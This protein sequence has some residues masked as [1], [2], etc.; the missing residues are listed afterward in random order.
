VSPAVTPS[1]A[2]A[3][4]DGYEVRARFARAEAVAVSRPRLL[5]GLLRT[6]RHVAE[7]PCG[8]GYFLADYA[9]IGARTTL[10]DGNG[11]MLATAIAHAAEIGLPSDRIQAHLR[12]VQALGEL[13]DVDLVVMPNTALNQLSC[14]TSLTELLAAI[15]Q[16]IRPGVELFA[17]VACI[18]PGGGI[19]TAG[20]YD[21]IRRHG[22]WF[23]DRCL[24]P[25][26]AGGAVLRRRRQHRRRDGSGGVGVRVEFDYV[27]AAGASL[28]TT[29][30]ELHLF[31]AEELAAALTSVGFGR[32][33]F[34][35]GCGGLSEVAAQAGGGDAR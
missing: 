31:S 21:P 20:S 19:D 1:A 30:I 25:S 34:L 27:D 17:Q 10:I 8:A 3:V 28:H 16:V 14:Q 18:Q 2:T 13:G 24:D 26:Q 6:A 7:V 5:R 4:V 29:S 11:A 33:R 23:A 12:Y 32:L 35:P 9:A 15:R 22:V